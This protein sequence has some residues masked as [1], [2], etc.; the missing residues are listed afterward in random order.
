[1]HAKLRRHFEKLEDDRRKLFS[2]LSSLQEYQLQQTLPSGKWSIAHTLTHLLTS[3]RMSLQY[4][5]KKSLGIDQ[6]GNS[7]LL[8]ALKM[9]IL[10]LSQRLPM[11][12]YKA[13]QIV[14]E[15]TPPT[16]SFQEL[17]ENWE[18][19]RQ[20]LSLFLDSIADKNVR[21]KIYKHPFMGRLDAAQGVAF[22]REHFI[23]H[24]PQMKRLIAEI[25]SVR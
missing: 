15:Q 12:K 5:K 4:M 24:L 13:P 21:K 17:Q 20:E 16:L 6:L 2:E 14:V 9:L 7:G 11:L 25:K 3:E 19:S 10:Q 1:M 18:A 22:L 23:H 8:E